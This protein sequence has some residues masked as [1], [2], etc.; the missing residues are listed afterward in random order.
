MDDRLFATF[1]SI[2]A[3]PELKDHTRSYLAKR[4][5]G[6]RR[7]PRPLRRLVPAVACLVCLLTGLGGA[8]AYFT[9]TSIISVDVNPS[10]E[11][12]V[13][14]FDRV[15]WVEGQNEDGEHLAQQL[16][17]RFLDCSQAISTLMAD[18]AIL[19]YLEQDEVL[20]LSVV[21]S[22]PV[23][24]Q[25]LLATLESCTAGRSNTYC[26][27]VPMEEVSQAHSVGL[28]YGKYRLYLLAQELD[29]S[30]TPE[31]VQEMTM[32]ELRDWLS[33]HSSGRDPWTGIGQGGGS[34]NQHGPSQGSGGGWGSGQ[35][36]G[37][38]GGH[39]QNT[40]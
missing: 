37:W 27:A 19:G 17:L 7:A 31:Q 20:S 38:Q 32:R 8:K 1:D 30:L 9:P 6:Y 35:G 33:A 18:P 4:T 15:I 39:H 26:C 14:R 11:L 2:R 25:E 13:N 34:G 36:N 24:S 28:S 29:P 40:Q 22:D 21:G 5:R 16:N 12:G 23:Q 10:L 3:E